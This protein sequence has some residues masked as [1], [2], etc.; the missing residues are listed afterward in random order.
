LI[1]LKRVQLAVIVF[2]ITPARR[3]DGLIEAALKQE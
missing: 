2:T 1:F 3:L